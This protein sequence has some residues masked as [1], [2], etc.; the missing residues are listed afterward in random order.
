MTLLEMLE[1][2]NELL[3]AKDG[4]KEATKKNNEAIEA[5]KAEIAQ[6][7]I[8]DDVPSISMGG[9]KFFLQDKTI[10]SKKS[11]EVLQAAGLDFLE[12]LREQGLGDIIV[13]TVNPRTLQST[14]KNLV[15]E[16][17]ELSEELAEIL[18]TYDTYEIG[19]RKDTNKSTSKAKG[20]K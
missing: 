16:T 9:Y 12:V 6:Q 18:N 1:E 4:L 3:E 13:E 5:K 7:M 15:D 14:V 11:E 17:G 8:D 2:Y 20:G 10:Y 19:R